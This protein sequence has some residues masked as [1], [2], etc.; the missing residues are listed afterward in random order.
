MMKTPVPDVVTAQVGQEAVLLDSKKGI[1]YGLNPVAAQ[2]W[3]GITG[4]LSD[5]EIV[6]KV[7]AEFDV[8]EDRVR[9]DLRGLVESLTR[10]GLLID[11]EP[12]S[13]S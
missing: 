1:Y 5:D 6:A 12:S 13:R 11:A 3:A 8:S 7:V 2:I 4:G 10:H 9:E